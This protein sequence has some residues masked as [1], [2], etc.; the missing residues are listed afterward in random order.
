VRFSSGAVS[1]LLAFE[2]TIEKNKTTLRLELLITATIPS[3]ICYCP[4]AIL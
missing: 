4:T 1:A 2:L 3:P